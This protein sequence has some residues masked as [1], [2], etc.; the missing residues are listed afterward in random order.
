MV[1]WNDVKMNEIDEVWS[2]VNRKVVMIWSRQKLH[3]IEKTYALTRLLPM[4][5]DGITFT[6]NESYDIWGGLHQNYVVLWIRQ[7][8][9][10][11]EK[12]LLLPCFYW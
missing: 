8:L 5:F 11:I 12:Q 9:H 10:S 4:M 7:A 3:S 1:N 2:W 6:I